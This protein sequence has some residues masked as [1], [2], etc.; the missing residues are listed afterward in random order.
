MASASFR[1][2]MAKYLDELGF[3]SSDAVP[4]VWLRPA[5]KDNGEEYYEYILMYV[6]D[7]LV[8]SHRGREVLESLQS[9]D[10]VKF[11]NSKISKPGM[12]LGGK[13]QLKTINGIKCWTMSGHK[14]LSAVVKNV[15]EYVGNTKFQVPRKATAPIDNTYVPELDET[16]KLNPKLHTY[17]Q[18]LIGMLRWGTELGRVD[19]LHEVSILSQFQASPREGH[20][21]QL[22]RIVAYIR[23]KPKVTI[24]MDPSFP[25]ID[26]SDFEVNRKDFEDYYRNVEETKPN[27]M[28][29]PRGKFVKTTAFVD[30]SFGQ[31]KRIENPI[32]GISFL[33]IVHR[34]FGIQ[35]NK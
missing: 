8:I 29:R 3:L 12:Y 16:N 10:R 4:D 15:E 7:I 13:L 32:Q 18:E 2:F 26:Y 28:P 34:Y 6:D 20:L 30:A 17:Y 19:I 33:Q 5:A 14:Y 24:Y 27:N 25:N 9:K 31:I 11:K 23:D 22:L 21:D 35:N 1:S